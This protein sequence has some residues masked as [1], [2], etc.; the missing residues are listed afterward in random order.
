[1][2]FFAIGRDPDRQCRPELRV[3]IDRIE[4]IP[5]RVARD[6][7][8]ARGTAGTPN[9]LSG[10]GR[11]RWSV[12]YPV[13]Y[14]SEIE[15]ALVRITTS[16]GLIAW[17]EAQAPLAPEVVC[18]IIDHLLAPA[19]AGQ[20]FGG[21]IEEIEALWSRM[22]STMRVRGQTGGF[23]L[24]AIAG[25]DLALWD[26]AGKIAQKPVCELIAPGSAK[27]SIPA[28]LSG[29]NGATMEEKT[30]YARR[31]IDEG[32]R[33]V[34]LYYE[35]DWNALLSLCEVLRPYADVAVDALWHLPPEH[36]VS[37][38]RDLDRLEALWLECPLMP[39]EIDAHAE[40]AQNI[41]T[42]IAVGESYRTRYEIKPF[43]ERGIARY[44]QPDLGRCGIT[45]SR[46]I[47]RLAGAHGAQIVPHVSIAFPPQLA[48][49]IHFAAATPNCSLSEFNP[50]VLKAANRFT[51][52]PLR[53]E[54]G[55]WLV[56][57]TPGLGIDVHL[58]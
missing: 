31:Y 12:D 32:Y 3:R 5:V 42:P 30:S 6:W 21:A 17:G 25:I 43:L 48:A 19:V 18:A 11:Y 7:E 26:L 46:R 10:S 8:S 50:A 49:A 58:T 41:E 20:E 45:E 38:A 57:E 23:M 36:A 39:E 13:L 9:A 14:S 44:I 4:A 27:R 22:Y 29:V 55:N 15:T 37:Y 28:Y 1:L 54:G 47:A 51:A 24:D 16:S 53:V 33:A 34:K 40:L 56:P 52:A 2:R 35:S